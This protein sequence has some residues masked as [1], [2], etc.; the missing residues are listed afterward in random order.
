MLGLL[1]LARRERDLHV[2]GEQRRS[3]QRR[4]G[5]ADDAADRGKGGVD[6]VLRQPK[7]CQPRLRLL[8]L[9]GGGAIRLL[10]CPE[11]ATQ[12]MQVSLDVQRPAKAR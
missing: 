10:R 5:F 3:L 12:A 1:D 4:A 6:V 11:V 7:Q 2:G 8:A 9:P